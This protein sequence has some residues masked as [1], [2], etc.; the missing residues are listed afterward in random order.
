MH[1]P[2]IGA[3]GAGRRMSGAD[4]ARRNGFDR[5]GPAGKGKTPP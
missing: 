5:A 4:H 1:P 2:L 3:I